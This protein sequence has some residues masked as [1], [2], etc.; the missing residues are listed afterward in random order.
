MSAPSS[1]SV[2]PSEAG[3]GLGLAGRVALV[4]G[5]ASGIGRATARLFAESGAR[6]AAV[7]VEAG[8]LATLAAEAGCA[9]IAADLS[10]PAACA[11]VVAEASARHGQL[12]ILVN[13]AAIL[14]R[15]AIADMDDAL[16]HRLVDVNLRSQFALCRAAATEM[17]PRGGRIVNVS[18]TAAF[19]GGAKNSSAYA[20]TK[21][22]S[23]ALTRVLARELAPRGIAVNGVCPGGI[24]TPMGRQ[25]LPEPEWSRHY[26]ANVPLRRAG[27]PEEVARA[28]LFVASDWAAGLSG[29]VLDVEGG[30]MLR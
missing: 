25:G 28:I 1:T 5:A 26:E 14:R 23:V 19:N 8:G 27:Q 15:V 24:D 20:I 6:V 18:S 2:A 17:L 10:D 16:W 29:H 21:G 11:R 4:T 22:G 3:A 13:A 12:D 30:L 7:D 9:T